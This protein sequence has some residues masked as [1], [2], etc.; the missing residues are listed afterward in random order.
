MSD[1]SLSMLDQAQ[2]CHDD[3]PTR[4]ADLLRRLDPAALAAERCPGLAFLLNHVLGEKLGAWAEAHA[5]FGPLLRAAGET[6]SPALWRQAATAAQLAGDEAAAARLGDALAAACGAS[7]GQA[8][9]AV[10]LT[11]AMYRTPALS[12]ADAAATVTLALRGLAAP[13]WQQPSA[14]DAAVAACANNI[15]SSLLER[16]AAELRQEPLRTALADMARLAERF[17]QRAGT[18]VHRERAAY[19][20]AMVANALGD[21]PQAR[22]HA[23]RALAMLDEHDAERAEQVDRAFI[24]L[25][26]ARACR[27]MTLRDE[28][29]MAQDAADELA[30]RFNDAGLDAWY[31]RRRAEL[32]APARRFSPG[33]PAA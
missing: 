9:E 19:L 22:E 21:A 14:L 24:E 25:E 28:A 31:A 10:F 32:G 8:R 6:P 15:A 3:D 16:P 17:W 26:R 33:S 30:A 13:S 23:V 29:K 18:W 4:A 1:P 12:A 5:L 7:T 11:A 20:R 2:A 27:D